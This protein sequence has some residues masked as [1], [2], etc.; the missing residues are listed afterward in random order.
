[1]KRVFKSR[2]DGW[3]YLLTVGIPIFVVVPALFGYGQG[4]LQQALVIGLVLF[5]LPAWLLCTTQYTV[6]DQYLRI[7]SGPFYWEV[8]RKLIEAIEPSN[9]ILSAPALSLDRLRIT[10]AGGKSVLV[11][12]KNRE[13]FMSA[14]RAES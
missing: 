10:Y 4:S 6:E 7:R 12:P 1:M 8:E 14:V 11:S 2:V 3:Y 9:S 5:A 13:E